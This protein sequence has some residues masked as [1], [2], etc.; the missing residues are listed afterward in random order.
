MRTHTDH[1]QQQFDPMAEA[2]LHSA[3]HAQGPDLARARELLAQA[4]AAST[5]ATP[6]RALDV[7]CGAG[8]L[9]YLLAETCEHVVA[10]DPSPQ[11]CATVA[12]TAQARGLEHLSSC[13]AGA[14]RLPFEAAS[15]DLVATRYSAH[16]WLR[17]TPAL[18][19][20][21]RVLRPAGCLLI[22]DLEAPA[23]AL[24]DTHLQTLELLRDPS[25]VRNRSEREWR[26]ELAAAGFELGVYQ[27]WP[28]R[29]QFDSW[30]GRMRTP[31]ANAALIRTLQQG[32][33]SEVREALRFEPDGTF[34]ART[35]LFWAVK[36]R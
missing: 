13:E 15:F 4:R 8:H 23:E 18:L 29:L 16:H 24:V 34:T 9:S 1:V 7:G 2:Y 28:L 11:M 36:S 5:L 22:I 21:R 14:E 3:V 32:A 33:P 35:A 19:E 10:L 25:H 6:A 20:M 26:A 17:L 31:A 12:R 30:V 27:S